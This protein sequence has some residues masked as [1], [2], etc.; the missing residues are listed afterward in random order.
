VI[1]LTNAVPYATRVGG[2]EKRVA[3]ALRKRE[4]AMR[5]NTARIVRQLRL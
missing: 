4:D 5:A 3:F 2:M 1:R